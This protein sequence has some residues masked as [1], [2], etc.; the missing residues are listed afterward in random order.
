VSFHRSSHGRRSADPWLD[1]HQLS[2]KV[3]IDSNGG[4]HTNASI[5]GIPLSRISASA[6][7]LLTE[8][9]PDGG[10][11]PMTFLMD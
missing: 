11:S 7:R 10:T 8:S 1:L 4:T 6:G 2:D 5:D 9:E 3:F